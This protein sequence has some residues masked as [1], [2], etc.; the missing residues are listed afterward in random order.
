MT[1]AGGDAISVD[2]KGTLYVVATPI[3]NLQD[4]TLRAIEV[5][6]S[7]DLI[8]AEDTRH[9]SKLLN[10]YGIKTPK[11]SYYDEIEQS[12][13]LEIVKK[14]NAGLN[15]ALISDSGTPGVSDPGYRL[16]N[17]AL[18]NAIRVIPIPGPSA[19]IAALVASG[20]ATDRFVFEGFLPRKKGRQTRLMELSRELRTIIIFESPIRLRKTLADLAVYFQDRRIVVAREIS[21]I[22]EE[23]VYGTISQL[24]RHFDESVPKGE[25]VIILEGLTRE[26]KRD[27]VVQ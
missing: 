26:V 17:L 20:F 6:K 5:L 18:L 11:V 15:I 4:I 13:S 27:Q 25:I 16:I 8:A 12:R 19:T 7:V 10:H 21:K 1:T 23:F 22:F 14:L 3:G 2:K 9:A 24:I